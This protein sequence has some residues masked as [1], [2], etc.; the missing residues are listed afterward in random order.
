MHMCNQII[1]NNKRNFWNPHSVKKT[2]KESHV[3]NSDHF[4]I[5]A[6]GRSCCLDCVLASQCL[7][8]VG[9][10]RSYNVLFGLNVTLVS[11]Q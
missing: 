6:G 5:L 11:M 2:M 4:S 8:F 10:S 7:Y 1:N 3:L 9:R